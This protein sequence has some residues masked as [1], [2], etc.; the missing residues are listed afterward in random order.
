M[1]GLSR[2]GTGNMA[3]DTMVAS[4]SGRQPGTWRDVVMVRKI[5]ATRAK[6]GFMF[7]MP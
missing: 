3:S 6:V 5:N 1:M 4:S 2:S 7:E